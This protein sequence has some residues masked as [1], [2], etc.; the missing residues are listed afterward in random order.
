MMSKKRTVT[1]TG[2]I[3]RTIETDEDDVGYEMLQ[4]LQSDGYEAEGSFTWEDHT[5]DKS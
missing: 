5:D 1:L 3:T 2:T 4:Q